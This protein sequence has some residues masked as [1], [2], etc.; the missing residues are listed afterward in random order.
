MVG[1]KLWYKATIMAMFFIAGLG[2]SLNAQILADSSEISGLW[3]KA[4]SQNRQD[5]VFL[6]L[7][8]GHDTVAV[9]KLDNPGITIALGTNIQRFSIAGLAAVQEAGLVPLNL[10]RSGSS[11]QLRICKT[12]PVAGMYSFY[13]KDD[14]LGQV[15]FLATDSLE[16]DLEALGIEA[17]RFSLL[18]QEILT[19]N[20]PIQAH[21]LRYTG[22]FSS[23]ELYEDESPGNLILLDLN[24]KKVGIL[25]SGRMEISSIPDGLYLWLD[26]K[27][28]KRGLYQIP[29]K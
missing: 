19:F 28:G 23:K 13:L 26:K 10:R 29:A 1:K 20:Q 18:V 4:F 15:F 6:D 24:G 2:F 7:T 22:Q 9:P 14:G 21:P 16:L 11:F 12:G 17:D 8:P 5:E 3:I 25:H 27:S